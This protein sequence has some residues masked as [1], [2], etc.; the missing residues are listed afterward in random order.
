VHLSSIG[1]LNGLTV[2][3]VDHEPRDKRQLKLIFAMPNTTPKYLLVEQHIKQGI[4]HKTI[5]DKLPGERTLAS[6]LGFSYM[7][8]RKAID[9]LVSEGVLFK[10]PTKGTFVADRKQAKPATRNIGYFLDSSIRSGLSSPYY[11]L[12][13]NALEKEAAQHGYATVYFSELNEDRPLDMLSKVDG[14]IVSCF[15]RIENSIQRIKEH[16]PVVAIDNASSDKT[17][18]SVIIDNFNAIS[19]TFTYLYQLGHRRIA[20]MTGLSDSDVG[21]NRLAGYLNGLNKFGLTVD[22]DLVFRGNYTFKCGLNGATHLLGLP[23]PPTAIICAND[24]MALGAIRRLHHEGIR[25]PEDISIVGFDDID[26]AAQIVPALTTVQAPIND[27]ITTAFGM[28]HRLIDNK[29]LDNRHVALPAKLIARQTC[30][31]IE[32]PAKAAAAS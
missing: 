13:F 5:V 23:S 14:V 25:V 12:I 28:L 30:N 22:E 3:Q 11:S 7:T 18:P 9:N 21:K 26:V 6:E 19:E 10:V 15:P 4:K 2:N 32:R 31:A 16:V 17:I 8:I 24:S 20:F 27:I 1:R 29:P